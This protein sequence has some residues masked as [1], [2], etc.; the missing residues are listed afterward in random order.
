MASIAKV[1]RGFATF[2]DREIASAF[3]G[4]QKAIVAGC[5]GLVA[6]N[7]P[8]LVTMYKDHPLVSALGV[9]DHQT[10]SVDID[11]LYNAFIPHLGNEK[12]PVSIPKIGT[13]K[14]GRE[15]IDALVRYIKEA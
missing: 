4:W 9:Y 5:G 10:E 8:K 14:I 1:Q 11:A 15:E 2:V 13:M 6:A 12:I 7:I 3:D